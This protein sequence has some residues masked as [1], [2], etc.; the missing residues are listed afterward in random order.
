MDEQPFYIIFYLLYYCSADMGSRGVSDRQAAVVRSMTHLTQ[1]PSG[2][3]AFCHCI[4]LLLPIIL[5]HFLYHSYMAAALVL[6]LF[7]SVGN[8]RARHTHLNDRF[9]SVSLFN[10]E[11]SNRA[12]E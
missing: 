6:A 12:A 7:S 4:Y 5:K 3:E 11:M 8:W 2:Y 9:P 10:Y 1:K